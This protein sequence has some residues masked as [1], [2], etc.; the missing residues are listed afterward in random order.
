MICLPERIKERRKQMGL[1]LLQLSE[2]TGVKEA[3]VQRWESG[4]IKTIKYETVE[5]LADVLHC[6]PAYLMGWD[7]ESS[8]SDEN[9]NKPTPVTE[10]GLEDPLDEQLMEYVKKL[11]PDQKAFLLAQMK[12]LIEQQ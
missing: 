10:D 9:K 8:L 7:E 4:N 5:L 3:T 6:S 11:T 2:K 12:A 1:T